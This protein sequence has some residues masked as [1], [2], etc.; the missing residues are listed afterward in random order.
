MS[1]IDLDISD[2]LGIGLSIEKNGV[3]FYRILSKSVEKNEVR[4]VFGF[5]LSEEKQHIIDFKRIISELDHEPF[6]ELKG[7]GSAYLNAVAAT[8]VFRGIES[9]KNIARGFEDD[10][11][12]LFFAVGFEKDSI[13]IY[14]E[15][16]RFAQSPN[17]REA[18]SRLIQQE[19]EH[20]IKLHGMISAIKTEKK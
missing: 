10:L 12:A 9:F 5:M 19:K 3:E 15:L 16:K 13:I 20:V 14:E 4:E 8:H 1:A 7:K 6:K 18:I 2:I 17:S 11:E